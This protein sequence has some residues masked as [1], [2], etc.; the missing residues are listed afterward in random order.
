M[1]SEELMLNISKLAKE[2]YVR[3]EI[4]KG[5]TE[6]ATPGWDYLEGWNKRECERKLLDDSEA[7]GMFAGCPI[8][9]A[10]GDRDIPE[11][12]DSDFLAH[13][14]GWTEGYYEGYPRGYKRGYDDG[15]DA[16]TD[17]ND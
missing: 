14:E 7:N 5:L 10:S 3:Q 4:A 13:D 2:V 9:K 15:Y 1:T 11:L 8:L 16:A 12:A 6:V 17:H